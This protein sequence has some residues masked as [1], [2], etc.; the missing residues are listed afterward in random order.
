MI[1]RGGPLAAN[2][3]SSQ[4]RPLNVLQAAATGARMGAIMATK[5][6][7]V[8]ATPDWLVAEMPAGYQTRF[9]EVQRLSAEMHAMD[10]MARLLWEIG[11]P[12]HEAVRDTF[13]SLKFEVDAAAGDDQI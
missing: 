3:H 8:A 12:L 13:A 6:T 11:P 7:P 1:A 4:I 2:T 10:R 5:T 9:A